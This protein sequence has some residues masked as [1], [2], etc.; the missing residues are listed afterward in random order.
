MNK[1]D[2][3]P[4]DLN[5]IT[6]HNT[7]LSNFQEMKKNIPLLEKK[8][9]TLE[10]M[11]TTE[12]IPLEDIQKEIQSLKTTLHDLQHQQSQTIYILQ[13]TPIIETFK[14]ELTKPI[15]VS[16][17]GEPVYTNNDI[18]EKLTREF[19]EIA[20]NYICIQDVI[21]KCANEC[22]WC[23]QSLTECAN[24]VC[25]CGI[26]Y[27]NVESSFSYKDTERINIT[28]KYT[29]DRR[30]HFKDCIN[31][32]QGKQNSTIPQEVYDKLYQQLENHGLLKNK[33]SITKKHVYMFLRETGFSKHYED[34]NLIYHK[35]TG[36]PLDDISHLEEILIADFDKLSE[37]YDIHYIKDKKIKRKNFINTQYVLFQLLK[38]H[39]Y[40]C[41]ASDFNF[42]KTNERRCFHDSICSELF[43]I[44][45]WNFTNV[46]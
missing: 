43:K 15:H 23:S 32:F 12:E 18:K 40:P 20:K 34:V 45:G 41:Q 44:L 24:F 22:E 46:F 19:S 5:I 33:S 29:Y 9:I 10:E 38:R 11:K 25:D 2:A 35:I 27:E 37:M 3:F 6:I 13:T 8:I 4:S 30:V 14:K 42:L 31:Q 21:K 36:A 1:K 28:S 39:K 7:I 16:F 26:E 17:M